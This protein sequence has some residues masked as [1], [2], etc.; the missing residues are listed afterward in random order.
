MRGHQ[1]WRLGVAARGFVLMALVAPV[2]WSRDTPALLALGTVGAIW[3]T[4]SLIELRPGLTHHLTATVE[5]TLVGAVCAF[6][7]HTSFAVLGALAVA[8]FTAAL[9][10]RLRGLA[11]ALFAELTAVVIVT[12][13]LFGGVSAE[14]GFAI[15]TW[16]ITGLGV[17]L[18]ATFLHSTL[19]QNADALNPYRYAQSLIRQLI[20]L[21]E[22][23][24]SGL[25]ANALG[26]AILSA[27]TDDLPTTGLVLYVPRGETLTTLI[28]KATAEVDLTVP[29]ELAFE[30]WTTSSATIEGRAFAFPLLSEAGTIA[31]VAGLLSERLDP[32][33]LDLPQRI[34]KVTKHLEASAVHLDTALMFDA[35]R[36]AATADERRRLAREMHD[37]VAQDI[38]SLGYLVDVLAAHP[39][40]QEQAEQIENLRGRI[41]DVVGEVRRSVVTLRT[42]VGT[43]ASLGTAIGTIARSL[44]E[45][46]GVPIQVTLDEH[47]ARLSPEVEAELF[48]IAQEAMNNAV[49]HAKASAIDVHCEVHPPE[50][51]ITVSDDGLGLQRARADS[52]GLQIMKE[53]A[54]LIDADLL[55]GDR[56][57]GGLLVSVRIRPNKNSERSHGDS[58]GAKVTI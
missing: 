51:L 27:V 36:A 26:G 15:F 29:E 14:A 6:S 41:T 38:A 42:S 19:L 23:L 7:V 1:T 30:A 25:D 34:R 17:G 49:K 35:F 16:A 46:S 8:P 24:S 4:A 11:L 57:F 52:H 55:I 54:R 47:T 58:D 31:V 32:N 12:K 39:S 22:G 2:L 53:R 13:I 18:I 9:Y 45:V 48:R 56:P 20:S 10:E 37:G 28:S 3:L 5:A 44:S 21:S 40:S 43:S 50:A 33:K